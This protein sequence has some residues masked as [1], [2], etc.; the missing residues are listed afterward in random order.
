V[1]NWFHRCNAKEEN[2]VYR[3]PVREKG[4]SKTTEKALGVVVPR[5]TTNQ[6]FDEAR[7]EDR[8][9]PG[10]TSASAASEEIAAAIRRILG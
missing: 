2:A 7:F 8:R 9:A 3:R 5:D 10:E 6:W 4:H 1:G